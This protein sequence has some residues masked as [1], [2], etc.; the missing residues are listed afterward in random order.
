MIPLILSFI[1]AVIEAQTRDRNNK[2]VMNTIKKTLKTV[3]AQGWLGLRRFLV[4]YFTLIFSIL[5]VLI[6]KW[7]VELLL[8]TF[9]LV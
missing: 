6:P 4:G 1:P 3:I 5:N 8:D 9:A 7:N 2:C